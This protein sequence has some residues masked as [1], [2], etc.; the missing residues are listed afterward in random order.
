MLILNC[1]FLH[2]PQAGASIFQLGPSSYYL[3]S[4]RGVEILVCF[5]KKKSYMEGLVIWDERILFRF[6]GNS[7]HVESLI[8]KMKFT[9]ASWVSFHPQFHGLPNNLIC[10]TG[11][12]WLNDLRNCA[13]SRSFF[14][15][16]VW[17][18]SCYAFG[19]CYRYLVF[20]FWHCELVSIVLL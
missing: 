15:S 1:I 3:G 11:K 7:P 4:S 14:G 8:H 9:V 12:R 19:V 13:L 18:L 16:F 10:L 17:I 5:A 20:Y 6:K 2:S